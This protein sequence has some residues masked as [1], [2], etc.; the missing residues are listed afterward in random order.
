VA[1]KASGIPL[2]FVNETTF[3]V[4]RH[5][6]SSALVSSRDHLTRPLGLALSCPV[7][8]PKVSRFS[9]PTWVA[10]SR[11]YDHDDRAVVHV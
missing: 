4:D 3:R 6:P 11:L 9:P 7:L 8:G 2:L 1:K 10:E 5:S